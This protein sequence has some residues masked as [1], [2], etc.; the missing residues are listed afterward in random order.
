M[1][2]RAM[3]HILH[4]SAKASAQKQWPSGIRAPQCMIS[5]PTPK[6][7]KSTPLTIEEETIIV[8][9]HRHTLLPLDDRLCALQATI[10]LRI[11]SSL[12]RCLQRH[13]ISRLPEVTGTRSREGSS[14]PIPSATAISTTAFWRQVCAGVVSRKRNSVF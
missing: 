1:E 13:G 10:P 7:T 8:A 6:D 11:R 9:F 12:H 2:V 14:R 4:G 5:P 3:G